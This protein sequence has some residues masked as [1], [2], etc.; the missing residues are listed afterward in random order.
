[1]VLGPILTDWEVKSCP[2]RV[3]MMK[4]SPPHSPQENCLVHGWNWD[5]ICLAETSFGPRFALA[6]ERTQLSVF[7]RNA[8]SVAPDFSSLGAVVGV[9]KPGWCLLR[10]HR[11]SSLE[12]EGVRTWEGARW[13][14]R[15]DPQKTIHKCDWFSPGQQPFAKEPVWLFGDR[16]RV[17]SGFWS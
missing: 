16:K 4:C 7:C 1:M 3:E 17:N 9:E 11:P 12:A 6:M 5:H 10:G 15:V 8:D 14:V 13:G 2:S